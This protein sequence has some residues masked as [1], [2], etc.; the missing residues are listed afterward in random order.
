MEPTG[1]TWDGGILG[2]AVVS[3]FEQRCSESISGKCHVVAGVVE[4]EDSDL[5]WKGKLENFNSVIKLF[6]NVIDLP[7]AVP[8]STWLDNGLHWIAA[9]EL[10]LLRP[11]LAAAV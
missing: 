2:S 6:N 1:A 4:T 8:V 5:A 9:V 7:V 10:V 11:V 3:L